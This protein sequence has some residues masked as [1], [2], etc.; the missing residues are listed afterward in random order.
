MRRLPFAIAAALVA[1]LV[2]PALAAPTIPGVV[3]QAPAVYSL[4][5]GD[6]KVTALSDG[7]MPMDLHRMLKGITPAE[8][9]RLLTDVFLANPVQPPIN[10]FLI[11][12][13]GCTILVDAGMGNAV[14]DRPR[15]VAIHASVW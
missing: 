7:T 15:S 11:K 5:I 14:A 13:G 8:M 9:D 4:T 3:L 10:C 12:V 2:S 1:A 6:A